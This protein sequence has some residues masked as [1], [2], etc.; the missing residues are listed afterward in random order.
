MSIYY[1]TN[2]IE[3]YYYKYYI[4]KVDQKLNKV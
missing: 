3:T 2:D 4:S 1:D